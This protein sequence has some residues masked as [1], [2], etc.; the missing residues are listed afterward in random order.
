MPETAALLVGPVHQL[1]WRLGGEA[2]VVQRVHDLQAGK[3]AESAVE[4]PPGWLAVEMAAEQH[5]Q[6]VR[7]T[8]GTAG[9][10][11]ADRIDPHG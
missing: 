2:E 1:E 3:H 8:S 4:L 5:R 6:P 7:I 11:V 9:E 10:H